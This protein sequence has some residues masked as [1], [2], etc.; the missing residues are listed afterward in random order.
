MNQRVT[1]IGELLI[2][3]IPKT[4]G[5]ALADVQ[6][7]TRAAGGAPANVAVAVARLRGDAAMISQVGFDAFGTHILSV[8]QA[9]GVNTEAVFR[10]RKANTG[11]AFVSLD[12]SGNR[13]FSFY[14][15]PSAD[16]FLSPEQLS[17]AMFQKTGILHFCSVD[18]V[19]A[20]V[21]EAHRRAISLAK[22]A[23]AIISFDP[24]VRLPLWDAPE[25]CAAAVREF[26]PQADIVKISDD[27]IEFLFGT[28]DPAEVAETLLRQEAC[29]L[30]YTKGAAGA[31]LFTRRGHT[32]VP[33]CPVE[34]VDT[35]GAGDAFVG[36]FLWQLAANS[37]DKAKLDCMVE[38]E[39]RA[40]LTFACRYGACTATRPGGA[41]AMATRE[42][43]ETFCR[44]QQRENAG[45]GN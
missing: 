32:L 6:E 36:A 13:D 1:A 25:H 24:N 21:K 12:G 39:R 45:S 7:F 38:E 28:D 37:I 17:D 30:L 19:D 16:L 34:V 10:T 23:G 9:A 4:K 3:F 22:K 35:T 29:A 44:A 5:I 18:L 26:L 33:S 2:D 14:R 8:L 43:F 41:A 42:E 31:E 27:E 40:L 15:N 20:P 11:L